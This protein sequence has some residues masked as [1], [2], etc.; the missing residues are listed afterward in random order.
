MSNPSE[1]KC[2]ECKMAA[3][4]IFVNRNGQKT[5]RGRCQSCFEK[6]IARATRGIG[7]SAGRRTAEKK[8]DV[9]ETKYG[10]DR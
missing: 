6:M 2:F 7:W 10:V 5:K 4:T 9:R 1:A 3:P 8:E